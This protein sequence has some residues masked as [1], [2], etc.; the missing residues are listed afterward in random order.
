MV[1]YHTWV[2]ER[3]K[4]DAMISIQQMLAIQDLLEAE[5]EEVVEDDDVNAQ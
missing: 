5:W 3:H 1:G 2:G 4:Q